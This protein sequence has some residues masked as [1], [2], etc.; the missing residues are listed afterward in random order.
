MGGRGLESSAGVEG[1]SEIRILK[2]EIR[3]LKYEFRILK[4]EFR[5]LKYG[6]RISKRFSYLNTNLVVKLSD[7]GKI[8]TCGAARAESLW[9]FRSERVEK[10]EWYSTS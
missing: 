8:R 10:G 3:I 6:F 9:T 2:Y 7:W 4:Y 5:T 1:Q